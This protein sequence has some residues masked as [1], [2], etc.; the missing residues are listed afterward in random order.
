MS[1]GGEVVLEKGEEVTWEALRVTITAE[2]GVEEEENA[3]S[4]S[5]VFNGVPWIRLTPARGLIFE[6]SRTRAVAVCPRARASL[7]V[8]E[9][10]TP[11]PP[12]K[13]MFIS[14]YE[15]DEEICMQNEWGALVE[16]HLSRLDWL[17]RALALGK[18][19]IETWDDSMANVVCYM[20]D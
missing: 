12:T 20:G 4:I 3:V 6:G 16:G 11:L 19:R 18:P 2:I 7:I 15:M 14:D 8:S 5:A 13:R 9:P 17:V 10:V 1:R